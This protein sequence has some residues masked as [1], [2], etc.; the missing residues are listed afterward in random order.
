MMLNHTAMIPARYQDLIK[1]C[2]KVC[3]P[4]MNQHDSD[5]IVMRFFLYFAKSLPDTHRGQWLGVG[6]WLLLN[7]SLS[8]LRNGNKPCFS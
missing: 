1:Y 3:K 7:T 6:Q 5:G 2:A 8:G 4:S